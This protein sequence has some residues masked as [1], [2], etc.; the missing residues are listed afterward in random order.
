MKVRNTGETQ[1][2]LVTAGGSGIGRATAQ[3][4]LMSGAQVYICDISQQA[5]QE[6]LKANPG[7]HGSVCDVGMPEQVEKMCREAS[8]VMGGVSVL[9]NNAGIGGPRAAVEDINYA[10]WDKTLRVNLSGMFY[11]VKQVVPRMKEEG[12][13]SIINIS[14]S[15]VKTGLP[16]RLAYVASK[17]GVLGLS[18]NLAREL[19]PF[20]I[21]SNSILPGIIDNTRGRALVEA[22]ALENSQSVEDSTEQF[23]RYISLRTFIQPEEIAG[24][25]VF[26]TSKAARNISGQEISVD[27][28]AEWE[29]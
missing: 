16:N 8:S 5:L 29:M 3:A 11:C 2:V 23:L 15:S 14:T 27:G 20:K 4:F 10:E 7:M 28:N 24:M 21:R 19:G 9:L 26:L 12:G 25:A 17:A 22:H 6:T 18:Y 1:R 13:G